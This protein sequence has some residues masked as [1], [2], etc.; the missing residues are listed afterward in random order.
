MT[1][2]EPGGGDPKLLADGFVFTEGPRWHAGEL[3]FSD[4]H[5]EAVYTTTPDGETT[6]KLETPGQKPSGGGC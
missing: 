4:M 5:G 3:W 6:L 2:L 1:A